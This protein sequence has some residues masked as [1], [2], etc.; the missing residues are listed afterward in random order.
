MS[1]LI[2]AQIMG[3]VFLAAAIGFL[4]HPKF[5]KN[6]IKDFEANEGLT[7]FTGMAIMIL[8]LVMVLNHNIWELSAAGIITVVGW[9]ALIKGAIFL[10]IP[11]WLFKISKPILKNGAVMKFAML[12]WLVAGT[13]LSWFG[14]FA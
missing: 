8:G 3:P 7:Y 2:L 6:A 9:G 1:T 13:Y 10:I 12:V 5:Y 4:L 14:F 11:S